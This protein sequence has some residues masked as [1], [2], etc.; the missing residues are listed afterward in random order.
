MDFNPDEFWDYTKR[1]IL[2]YDKKADLFLDVAG[3]LS[4]IRT[5]HLLH[6]NGIYLNLNYLDSIKKSPFNKISQIFSKGKKAK[7]MLMKQSPEDLETIKKWIIDQKLKVHID[8]VFP[9]NKINN[10]HL[11]LQQGNRKGK[12]LITF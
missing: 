8:K 1:N 6:K 11:T 10:A 9:L 7:T 12:T 2:D 5:K 3:N 4:F